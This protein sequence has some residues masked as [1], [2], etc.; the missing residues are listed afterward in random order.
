MTPKRNGYEGEVGD[1]LR[2][3]LRGGAPENDTMSKKVE[4]NGLK[5]VERSTEHDSG[6]QSAGEDQGRRTGN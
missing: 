5:N 4:Q 3:T 6:A 1:A 2:E